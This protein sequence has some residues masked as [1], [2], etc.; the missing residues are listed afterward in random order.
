[1]KLFIIDDESGTLDAL[2]IMFSREGY[3]VDCES[4]P[5]KAV[6][7]YPESLYNVVLCDVQM[8]G[9]SGVEVTRQ[10]KRINPLANVIIMTA[11]SNMSRVI[12]CIEAGACDYI[13]KPFTD[14]DLV[15]G[16]VHTA[17][18]RAHRWQQ[19]FGVRVTD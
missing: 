7:R 15:T 14:T 9:M 10:I 19:S 16:I 12:A 3:E 2:E 17:V 6:S 5:Q 1:M 8:P 11:Y 4:D 18:E 13:T